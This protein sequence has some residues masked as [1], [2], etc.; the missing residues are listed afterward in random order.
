LPRPPFHLGGRYRE[1]AILEGEHKAHYRP[2]NEQ[3][4][5][6]KIETLAEETRGGRLAEAGADI[7]PTPISERGHAL[8]PF[9]S[10]GMGNLVREYERLDARLGGH[11]VETIEDEGLETLQG[12]SRRLRRRGDLLLEPVVRGP[13]ISPMSLK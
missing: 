7:L 12:I 2:R 1:G 3:D 13:G 8:G 5:G 11:G 9:L 10:Q 6:V 4:R